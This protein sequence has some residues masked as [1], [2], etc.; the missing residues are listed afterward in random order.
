VKGKIERRLARFL[1]RNDALAPVAPVVTFTFDDAYSAACNLGAEVV[2]QAGGRATYY[3]CG[4]LDQSQT[5]DRN[6]HSAADLRR[7]QGNGHE[8]ACH[9]YGHLNYQQTSSDDI[10]RDLD[11]NAQYFEEHGIRLARNFAYAFGCVSPRVKEICGARFR[12]SRGVQP[13]MNRRRLDLSLLKSVPLY[14]STLDRGGVTAL[15]E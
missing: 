10:L 1:R 14:S 8:V 3:V 9:G 15:V 2:E 7:L 12:S 5:G 6:R 11:R 4:G 13:A